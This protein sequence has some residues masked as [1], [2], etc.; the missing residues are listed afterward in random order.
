VIRRKAAEANFGRWHEY[1]AQ[2]HAVPR[3]EDLL[4]VRAYVRTDMQMP[5][6]DMAPDGSRLPKLLAQVPVVLVRKAY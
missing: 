3:A 2:E 4:G 6:L 1:E 5:S